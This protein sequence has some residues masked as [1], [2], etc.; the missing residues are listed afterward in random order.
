MGVI[1]NGN[2]T[3]YIILSRTNYDQTELVINRKRFERVDIFKYLGVGLDTTNGRHEEVQR[4]VGAANICFGMLRL[5]SIQKC[6]QK[7]KK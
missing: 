6:Y 5:F 7:N 1:I 4:R 3:K 2:K